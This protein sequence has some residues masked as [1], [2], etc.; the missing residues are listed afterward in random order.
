M[1]DQNF[2]NERKALLAELSQSYYD[3]NPTVSDEEFD[4][5]QAEYVKAGGEE[6]VGHGYEVAPDRKVAHS[7]PMGSLK[8]IRADE[9]GS[10]ALTAWFKYIHDFWEENC[11][12]NNPLTFSV[13]PKFDGLAI[14]VTVEDGKVSLAATRGDGEV[15]ENVTDAALNI[16][17]I[18]DLTKDGIYHGEVLLPKENLEAANELR[19]GNDAPLTQIR[20]AAAGMLRKENK[21]KDREPKDKFAQRTERFKKS[22]S[23]LVFADHNKGQYVDTYSYDVIVEKVDEILSHFEPLRTNYPVLEGKNVFIDGAVFKVEN[24]D[25]RDGLGSSSGSPRWAR[26]YKYN[27]AAY[28]SKVVDIE[29]RKPG[30]IGRIT[31]VVEYETI[32]IDGGKYTKATAHNLTLFKALDPRKGDKITIIKSGDVI[33]KVIS[34]EHT[35]EQDSFEIPSTCPQCGADTVTDG[36]FLVCTNERVKCDPV[37][38]LT[39]II[40]GLGIKGIQESII[41]KVYDARLTSYENMHDALTAMKN[42]DEGKIADIT[43]EVTNSK[44]EISKRTLGKKMDQKIHQALDNAWESASL[45]SWIYGLN[46]DRVGTTVSETLEATYGSLE[47]ILEAIDNPSAYREVQ[48]LK[49]VNWAAIAANRDRFE[50]LDN[51]IK[52]NEVKAPV[53]T[54]TAIHDDFWGG[55]KVAVTGTLPIKRAEA[56]GWL[57]AHG[58]TISSSFDILIDAGT[59][60]SSKATKARK[61]NKTVIVG[62]DFMNNYYNKEGQN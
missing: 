27:D 10:E 7:V 47:G 16:P 54:V 42:L 26:A 34:V 45:A 19:E 33:P 46:V 9:G 43:Y 32:L 39:L 52:A 5:L 8:K 28:E 61:Q 21:P 4:R 1:S 20:N 22:S 6:E 57:K 44:G 24:Q 62:E 13:S 35:G 53:S 30:K 50:F 29:W 40:T 11:D 25:V 23:L 41:Q 37:L 59:G 49:G 2:L 31:P 14:A 48:H 51:W 55:K 38:A 36:E 3:G 17:Q 15:G 56:E 12:T 60:N 18:A 58:A